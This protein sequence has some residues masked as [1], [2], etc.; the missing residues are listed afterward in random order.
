MG[1]GTDR[2]NPGQYL[3]YILVTPAAHQPFQEARSFENVEA[4]R[5]DSA[6]VQLHRDPTMTFDAS[7]M[8]DLNLCAHE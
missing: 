7:E 2:A 3:R 4:D 1:D 8:F 5:R 6:V